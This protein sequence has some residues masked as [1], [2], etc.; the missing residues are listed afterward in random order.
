MNAPDSTTSAGDSPDVAS[1]L[2]RHTP[3]VVRSADWADV[4]R[5]SSRRHASRTLRL[6]AAAVAVCA[7][8]AVLAILLIAAPAS[9]HSSSPSA[10]RTVSSPAAGIVDGPTRIEAGRMGIAIPAGWTGRSRLGGDTGDLPVIQAGDFALPE[11]DDDLGSVAQTGLAPDAIHV[12][13]IDYGPGSASGAEVRSGPP[14]ITRET[15]GGYSGGVAKGFA[16][17][18]TAVDGHSIVVDVAF[19]RSEPSVDQLRRANE[20]LATFS[21]VP[22]RTAEPGYSVLSDGRHFG[23]IRSLTRRG[24]EWYLVF[25]PARFLTSDAAAVAARIAGAVP[26][27]DRPPGDYYIRN[28]DRG[29]FVLTVG[30][31]VQVTHIQCRG[32]CREGLRGDVGD[33]AASFGAEDRSSLVTDYRGSR[34]QYWITIEGGKLT[35]IDEMY[36]P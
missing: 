14:R 3:P 11:L 4:V 31:A 10:A 27:G 26:P 36:L 6:A 35:R 33:L 20:I 22:A 2:D 9:D 28:V 1:L 25:D 7:L 12:N 16:R 8:G 32:G 23:Y 21:A 15:L 5:R 13:L 17:T 18:Q 30:P 19:G 24:G 34:S 29:S